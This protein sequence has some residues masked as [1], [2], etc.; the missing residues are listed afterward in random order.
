[1][2]LLSSAAF[3]GS[4]GQYVP[5]FMPDTAAWLFPPAV[6]LYIACTVVFVKSINFTTK[7]K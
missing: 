3:G 6:V 2:R 1:M 5:G 7:W 4:V